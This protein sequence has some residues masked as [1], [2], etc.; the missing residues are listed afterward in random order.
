METP[1]GVIQITRVVLA[2]LVL[3]AVVALP[4]PRRERPLKGQGSI[5][6]RLADVP[7]GDKGDPRA[8]VYIVD[9]LAP[10][11]VIHRRIELSN[12]S[13]ST[14][15]IA[16]YAS[17]ATIHEGAFLG[18][19]GHTPNE[20]STCTSVHPNAVGLRAGGRVIAVQSDPAAGTT[21]I[22][23]LPFGEGES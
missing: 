5:G 18:A 20:L 2:A 1:L 22:V 12:T 10:G 16:L 17:A 6:L 14:T 23:S 9:H 8:L 4:H 19:E 11:S 3:T 15:H 13:P 7:T 21:F